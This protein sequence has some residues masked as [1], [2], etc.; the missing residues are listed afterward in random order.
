MVSFT[1]DFGYSHLRSS[2]TVINTLLNGIIGGVA[3]IIMMIIVPLV[4]VEYFG[5][6]LSLLNYSWFG[7]SCYC[8]VKKNRGKLKD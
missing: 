5:H 2:V 7:R 6:F 3:S 1:Q 8:N 4:P